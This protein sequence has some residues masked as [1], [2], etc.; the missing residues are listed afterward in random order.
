MIN[1]LKDA[2]KSSKYNNK[3]Y[4]GNLLDYCNNHPC[5]KLSPG[6][7]YDPIQVEPIHIGD[8]D[9]KDKSDL[10]NLDFT[11]NEAVNFEKYYWDSEKNCILSPARPTNIFWS[12]HLSNMMQQNFTLN[13]YFE[14]EAEINKRRSELLNR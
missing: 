6:S 14:H 11:H 13:E 4:S 10:R 9:I 3:S 1:N 7:L 8:F 12:K 5:L 2:L